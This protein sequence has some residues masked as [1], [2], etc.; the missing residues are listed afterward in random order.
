MA[1]T[2]PI[3]KKVTRID[4]NVEEI[5]KIICF[6][7]QFIV[8][9]DLWQA[10]YQILSIIFLK[11]FID[12]NRILGTMI[13]DEKDVELNVSIATAFLNTQTLNII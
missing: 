12:S 7:L 3:E 9:Q 5:T 6:I 11:D 8:V 1:F 13:K 10:H 4:K 2:F